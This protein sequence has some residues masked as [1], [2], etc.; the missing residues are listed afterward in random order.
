M[1]MYDIIGLQ[2]V[3]SISGDWDRSSINQI[4]TIGKV[5]HEYQVHAHLVSGTRPP[6]IRYTPT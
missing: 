2:E 6:S 3:R 5:L 1:S 4:E